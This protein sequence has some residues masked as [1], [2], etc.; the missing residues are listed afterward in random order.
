MEFRRK[1]VPNEKTSHK[2]LYFL[3]SNPKVV[4]EI[5]GALFY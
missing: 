4:V 5:R 3:G 2:K 1:K